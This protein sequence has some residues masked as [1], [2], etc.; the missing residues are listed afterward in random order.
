MR[1]IGSSGIEN[2]A[3]SSKLMGENPIH[4]KRKDSLCKLIL[5]GLVG[6]KLCVERYR[7]NWEDV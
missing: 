2:P 5:Q 1:R 7:A 6:P 4:R 3:G